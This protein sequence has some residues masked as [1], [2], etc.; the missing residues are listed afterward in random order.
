[1][2]KAYKYRLYPNKTVSRK[3]SGILHRCRELYN[4][5]LS[6]RKDAYQQFQRTTVIAGE[7]R[8]VAATMNAAIN[9]LA[10]GKQQLGGKRPT[11]ATA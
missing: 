10:R 7:E 1:M 3:L 4:A 5:A 6:E 9:I 11:S 8:T 2:L